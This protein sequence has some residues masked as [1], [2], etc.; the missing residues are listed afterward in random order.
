VEKL[1]ANSATLP[2][3]GT[4]VEW[5]REYN[6]VN[7]LHKKLL[8]SG[9]APEDEEK[10]KKILDDLNKPGAF[11]EK[12]IEAF[13][14]GIFSHTI[15]A[16]MAE[17]HAKPR[18]QAMNLARL[19]EAKGGVVFNSKKPVEIISALGNPKTGQQLKERGLQTVQFLTGEEILNLQNKAEKGSQEAAFI[20]NQ[21][22]PEA[23]QMTPE[24]ISSIL[25]ANPSL[26]KKQ[27]HQIRPKLQEAAFKQL[28]GEIQS[29]IETKKSTELNKNVAEA[30]P[31]IAGYA[32]SGTVKDVFDTISPR[33]LRLLDPQVQNEYLTYL[34]NF[35]KIKNDEGQFNKY[36]ASRKY[37]N[38]KNWIDV[39]KEY[40]SKLKI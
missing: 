3:I 24:K 10:Y 25:K 19:G 9:K 22:L 21:W 33:Q 6:R 14:Q 31:L 15:F 37:T 7:E 8:A 34:A 26:A 28:Q 20:L 35:Y 40:R 36:V 38:Q 4:W 18:R 1:T 23:V 29:N 11:R 30:I 16:G 12:Q 39:V 13:V 27:L 5:S 2:S 17:A 32:Q